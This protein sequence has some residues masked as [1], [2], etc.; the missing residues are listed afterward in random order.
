MSITAVVTGLVIMLVR[1]IKKIPRRLVVFLWAIPFLRMVIPFGLNS[2]YSLMSLL[3]EFATKTIVVYEPV[4]NVKISMMNSIMAADTYF[5]ITYKVNVLE[6]V[7]QVASVIWIIVAVA[8]VLVLV[9]TYLITINEIKDSM[10]LKDNIYISEEIISPAVYG[11]VKPKIYCRC[12]TKTE[13]WSLCCCTKK[14][15]Y[16]VGTICGE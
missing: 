3:S 6:D 9:V 16:E 13:I 4:D 11:I 1:L 8:I 12:R 2:A 7:F 10:H 15:I 5:P 14:C